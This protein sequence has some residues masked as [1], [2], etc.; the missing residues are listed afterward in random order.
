M[1]KTVSSTPPET[2]KLPPTSTNDVVLK[3]ERFLE[4]TIPRLGYSILIGFAFIVMVLIHALGVKNLFFAHGANLVLCAVVLWFWTKNQHLGVK[5]L[6]E[7]SN[8]QLDEI[9]ELAH[10]GAIGWIEEKRQQA[11][12]NFTET[13][14]FHT[15]V[16]IIVGMVCTAIFVASH[17]TG[18]QKSLM[19]V[20]PEAFIFTAT[21]LMYSIIYSGLSR[22]LRDDIFRIVPN[23]FQLVLTYPDPE[24]ILDPTNRSMVDVL[25][26]VLD[27]K[28]VTGLDQLTTR[29]SQVVSSSA[30]ALITMNGAVTDLAKSFGQLKGSFQAISE[31]SRKY[32]EKSNTLLTKL[33]KAINDIENVNENHIKGLGKHT[34]DYR[35]QLIKSTPEVAQKALDMTLPAIKEHLNVLFYDMSQKM[36]LVQQSVIQNANLAVD[37]HI[38][39]MMPELNT[40]SDYIKRIDQG[41]RSLGKVLFDSAQKWPANAAQL[42][43]GLQPLT[44]AFQ[45]LNLLLDK[46]QVDTLPM[47]RHLTDTLNNVHSALTGLQKTLK[48]IHLDTQA[49]GEIRAT[50]TVNDTFDRV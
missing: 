39:K 22:Y 5:I 8:K 44:L 40:M 6:D 36:I 31:E 24:N 27:D 20:A 16:L 1:P 9:V 42:G 15:N 11:V 45:E 37:Q 49:L 25:S 13:F 14:V 29:L 46:G 48:D 12:E 23:R 34:E 28:V 21:A 41:M 38:N 50:L 2:P 7:F 32:L 18:N 3:E 19:Q 10:S 47:H 30:E 17:F 33:E 43:E 26:K 35:T 4:K